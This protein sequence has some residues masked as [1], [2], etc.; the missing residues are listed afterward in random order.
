ML[1]ASAT[2]SLGGD[3]KFPLVSW[4]VQL[5]TR[6]LDFNRFLHVAVLVVSVGQG[7]VVLLPLCQQWQEQCLLWWHLFAHLKEMRL[8]PLLH[9]RHGV[10]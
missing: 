5:L 7:G 3:F 8:L 9:S 10:A 1:D 2:S 4:P 6:R